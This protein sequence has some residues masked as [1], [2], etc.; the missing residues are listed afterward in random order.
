MLIFKFPV[1]TQTY[2]MTFRLHFNSESTI[3]LYIYVCVFFHYFNA[4][5]CQYT[6]IVVIRH[7]STVLSLLFLRYKRA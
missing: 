5:V 1:T 3:T 4:C 6:T 7:Y 2:A